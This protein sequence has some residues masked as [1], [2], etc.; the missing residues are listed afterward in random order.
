MDCSKH[1][2]EWTGSGSSHLPLYS[3]FLS[4]SGN[5]DQLVSGSKGSDYN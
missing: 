2:K 3:M 4:P 5:V 1:S